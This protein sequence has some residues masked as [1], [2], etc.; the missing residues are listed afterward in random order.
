MEFEDRSKPCILS[1]YS[2]FSLQKD[3]RAKAFACSGLCKAGGPR[4]FAAPFPGREAW[5]PSQYPSDSCSL[6]AAEH[7]VLG[8]TV[9]VSCVR[10]EVMAGRAAEQLCKHS[11]LCQ[12]QPYSAGTGAKW[13][14]QTS[15]LWARQISSIHTGAEITFQTVEVRLSLEDCF[16]VMVRGFAC[17]DIPHICHLCMEGNEVWHWLLGFRPGRRKEREHVVPL[18]ADG[19]GTG[20]VLFQLLSP[21]PALRASTKAA[22]NTWIS[23][24]AGMAGCPAGRETV[25]FIASSPALCSGWADAGSG[26][27][28]PRCF[29]HR[30]SGSS[31]GLDRAKSYLRRRSWGRS[32]AG[33]HGQGA[34]VLGAACCLPLAPRG[35]C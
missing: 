4:R 7:C 23:I 31:P 14:S 6:L 29:P 1:L 18:H 27:L 21:T 25:H 17:T 24:F 34:A 15:G 33:W 10:M 30:L 28:S 22:Q 32:P 13:G 8:F 5:P 35:S 9:S 12:P 11:A 3:N 26:L 19:E 20:A 2:L 16:L